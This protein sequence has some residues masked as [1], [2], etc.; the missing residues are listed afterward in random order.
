MKKIN[1]KGF[2]LVEAFIVSTI[3]LAVLVFMFIQIRTIVNGF[4]KSFS[5]NTIPGIYIANELGQFITTY[6]YK[7]AV[8]TNGYVL[9]NE[10][11]ED[12]DK[13][14]NLWNEMLNNANVKNLIVSKGNL[15]SLKQSTNALFSVELINYVN[16]LNVEEPIDDYRIIV[17]FNDNTYASVRLH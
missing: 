1:Q 15:D 7:D 16:S 14:Y 11:F 2:M 12:Y 4:N 13:E 3:V 9:H 6:D 5:Y 17:E 10:I 8:D